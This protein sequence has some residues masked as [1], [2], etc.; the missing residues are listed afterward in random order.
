VTYI[1]GLI[2]GKLEIRRVKF[3]QETNDMFEQ[4]NKK[5]RKYLEEAMET[6]E[7]EW[8]DKMIQGKENKEPDMQNWL[9][10]NC[11]FK[12]QYISRVPKIEAFQSS[13]IN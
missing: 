1:N 2:G 6:F 10:F 11:K 8:H 9:D 5:I 7:R 13:I 3:L 4:F 12:Y